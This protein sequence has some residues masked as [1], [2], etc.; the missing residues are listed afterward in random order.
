MKQNAS[1]P[2]EDNKHFQVGSISPSE[3]AASRRHFRT[4]NL[5]RKGAQFFLFQ[6]RLFCPASLSSLQTLGRKAL[7]ASGLSEQ[8]RERRRDRKR[9]DNTPMART[10]SALI[11]RQHQGC[12]LCEW[13]KPA[14]RVCGAAALLPSEN[15]Q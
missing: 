6:K 13:P 1:A 10:E 12:F 11:G 2:D 15:G 3:H 5:R 14:G 9:L 8:P 4:I 7:T